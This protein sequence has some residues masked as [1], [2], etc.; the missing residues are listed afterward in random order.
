MYRLG[1]RGEDMGAFGIGCGPVGITEQLTC[2]PDDIKLIGNYPNPFNS[3][4]TISFTMER[5]RFVTLRIYNLLGR[6]VQKLVEGNKR[7]GLHNVIFD[8]SGLS[9]G[10]YFYRLRPAA[11]LNLNKR[12]C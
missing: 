4:T 1:L 2:L 9:G 7:Q 11:L 5:S 6:E 8:A 10:I 12:C 3:T